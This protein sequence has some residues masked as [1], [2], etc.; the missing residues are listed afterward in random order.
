MTVIEKALAEDRRMLNEYEARQL[1]AA[2]GFPA[3]R[4]GLA[5]SAEDAV[6]AAEAIGFPVAVKAYGRD[7]LHKTEAG[8]VFLNV[9]DAAGV[10]G[11]YAHM[12]KSL[13]RRME[14]VVVSEMVPGR[15][16]LVMGL[17][18]EAGFSPCVMIGIGGV[19]AEIINDTAFRVAPI[20]AAEA[21]D[22]ALDLR[23]RDIF[24]PFRG[25]A[26][27]DMDAVC[28]CLAAMGK[29]GLD[30]PEIS[31]IDVNPVIIGPDG[32]LSAVDALVVLEGGEK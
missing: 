8:A 20:D 2:Y 7:L 27:A 31:E 13:G 16:E 18:R 21:L 10:R 28:R 3:M 6:N 11:A 17:H 19:M 5:G 32:T 22:M 1:L 12:E 15:R 24:G 23:A 14:G 4:E 30:F 25:E 26:A 9:A 29:I